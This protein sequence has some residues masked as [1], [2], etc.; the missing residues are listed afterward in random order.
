MIAF[1]DVDYR[2]NGAVAAAVLARDWTDAGPAAEVVAFIPEVA[3][4]VPGEFYRRELP[5]LLTVL[6]RCPTAPDAIVVDGYV[7][8]GPDRPGLGAR[9]H[10]ALAGSVPVVGVGKTAFL[11]AAAVAMPVPRGGSRQ[12]LWVTAAGID[13]AVAAETVRTMHGPHRIPTL[14]R[15]ADRLARS[16]IPSGSV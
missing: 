11:S 7:W 6:D 4:Y 16:A 12:P 1:L 3:E 15:R 2:D 9:L 8:L 13:P 10:E 14:L 5:C